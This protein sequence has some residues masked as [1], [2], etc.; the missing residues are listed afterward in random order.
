MM[1]YHKLCMS[2]GNWHV[3]YLQQSHNVYAQV[4]TSGVGPKPIKGRKPEDSAQGPALNDGE[5][6]SERSVEGGKP[7]TY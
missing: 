2:E 1:C 3:L 5:A 4:S 7:V 6:Q